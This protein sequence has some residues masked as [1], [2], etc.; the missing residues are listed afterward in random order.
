ML[1]EVA[2]ASNVLEA[3]VSKGAYD[4]QLRQQLGFLESESVAINVS[5]KTDQE[6]VRIRTPEQPVAK[7]LSG[8]PVVHETKTE[9]DREAIFDIPSDADAND[10]GTNV[11]GLFLKLGGGLIAVSLLIAVPVLILAGRKPAPT[12]G[13]KLATAAAQKTPSTTTSPKSNEPVGDSPE[14]DMESPEVAPIE[15]PPEATVSDSS[16]VATPPSLD[17][18]GEFT[19]S[20][21]MTLRLIPAGSFLMGSSD[22]DC[23][24]VQGRRS[25]VQGR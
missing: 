3:P 7:P 9:P 21:G 10:P 17:S 5:A 1:D 25:K 23:R 4:I 8:L 6:G 18:D 16:S 24:G 19:N 11:D 20:I 13:Q 15:L 14:V 2:D 12:S 22:A